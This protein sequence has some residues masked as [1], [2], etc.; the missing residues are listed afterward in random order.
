MGDSP[1]KRIGNYETDKKR[2]AQL[3]NVITERNQFQIFILQECGN[4]IV[5]A[6]VARPAAL[7]AGLTA[8]YSLASMRRPWASCAGRE[9]I[10]KM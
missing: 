3:P 7:A 8:F 4:D 2:S 1:A 5:L 10:L 6:Q 9:L